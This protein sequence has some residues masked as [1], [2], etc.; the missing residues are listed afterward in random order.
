MSLFPWQRTSLIERIRWLR[1]VLPPVLI[2]VVIIYQLGIA[3]SLDAQ[4]KITSWNRGVERMVGYQE[5]AIVGQPL[6]QL[7]LDAVDLA[8]THQPD[9]VLLDINMPEMD[10]VEAARIITAELPEAGVIILT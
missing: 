9:I 2:L 10:G 4:G 7:L 5:D 3:Q 8:R 6:S 1:Y